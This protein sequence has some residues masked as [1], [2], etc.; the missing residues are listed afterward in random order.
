MQHLAE[1]R[2]SVDKKSINQHFNGKN[3]ILLLQ[4]FT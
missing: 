3:L 2:A 1:N 4:K